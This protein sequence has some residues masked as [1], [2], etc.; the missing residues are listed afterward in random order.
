M[1]MSSSKRRNS[2]ILHQEDVLMERRHC[3]N[4]IWQAAFRQILEQR[5]KGNASMS[6]KSCDHDDILEKDGIHSNEELNGADSD[7][8]FIK[9]AYTHAKN[10]FKSSKPSK[11]NPFANQSQAH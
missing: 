10:E 11:A 5:R 2:I 7:A 4:V 6:I 8:N 9:H 3:T 1:G